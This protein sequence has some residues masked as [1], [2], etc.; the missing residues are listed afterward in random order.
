[1]S[2][3]DCKSLTAFYNIIKKK[4]N[5]YSIEKTIFH[6]IN[7]GIVFEHL[8][9]I[10][11]KDNGLDFSFCIDYFK[12]CKYYYHLQSNDNNFFIV[13]KS[14]LNKHQKKELNS[15]MK[16]VVIIMDLYNMKKKL[17]FYILLNPFKRFLPKT[18]FLLPKHINGGFT[19]INRNSIYII[20]KEDYEKVIIHELLHHNTRIHNNLW[21]EKNI[22]ILKSHFNVSMKCDLDPNEAV[23][24]AF[25]CIFDSCFVSLETNMNFKYIYDNDKQ[26]SKHISN[27]IKR[28]QNSQEWY[29][30]TNTMC[31]TILKSIIFC[32]FNKFLK[33]FT[34]DNCNTENITKFII[35]NDKQKE[36][37]IDRKFIQ[38]NS[39]NLKY[40]HKSNTFI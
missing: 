8:K 25:A 29:E 9:H 32:N 39:L 2:L 5:E 7:Q 6:K 14:P 36:Y 40:D 23:I 1:M 28:Y 33:S 35:K 11:E 3:Y 24:E 12:K 4:Y 22:D 30:E 18:G 20:R 37:N 27:K 31:Y 26:Y 13:S 17:N 34:Y 16:R 10:L 15:I 19:F 21:K 38:N